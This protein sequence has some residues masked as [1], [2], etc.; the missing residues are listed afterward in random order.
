[1]GLVRRAWTN[2]PER[3]VWITR[4]GGTCST[5]S[6]LYEGQAAEGLQCTS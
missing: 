5:F 1:M 6:P 2:P 3:V 4:P